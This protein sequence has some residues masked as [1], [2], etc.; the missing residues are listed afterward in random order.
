MS[1]PHIFPADA[2]LTARNVTRRDA[3]RF[4]I[5]AGVC[6]TMLPG[7]ALAETT[8]EK[9]DAAQL[10]YEQAQAELEAI[11]EEV[12]AA[13]AQVAETQSQVIEVSDQISQ[14]QAEFRKPLN[15]YSLA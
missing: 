10:S 5:G 12:A 8:Q 2:G 14:K 4:F 1:R 13:A 9:L 3:L 11:G 7:V 15:S 6:A